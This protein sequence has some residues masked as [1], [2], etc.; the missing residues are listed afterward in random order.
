[1]QTLKGKRIFLRA[2]EPEDLDWLFEIENNQELWEVSETQTP[3]SKYV[4]YQY[5]EDAHKDIYEA[6]QL[7][8]VISTYSKENV[9]CVDLFDFNAKNKRAGVGILI[10][11]PFQNQGIGS[12]VLQLLEEYTRHYLQLHQIYAHI[13]ESNIASTR[14]FEKAGFT[15]CGILKDWISIGNQFKDVI[16]YQKIL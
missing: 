7:R 3:F 10:L 6:K 16:I 12:E 8:L 2:L 11:K 5:L 4:L 15:A 1:M 13:N 9:G 14:L